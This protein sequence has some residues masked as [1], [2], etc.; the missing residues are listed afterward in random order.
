MER[1]VATYRITAPASESRARA[2]A[3]ATEQSVEM[4]L[5]AIEDPR[6]LE[7]IVAQVLD[8]RPRGAFFEVDLGIAPETTGNEPAQLMNMLFGNCS[9]Q[10]EIELVDVRFPSGYERSFPGPRFGIDGI[11]KITGAEGRPLTCTALK[12]QGSSI[13]HLAGVAHTFALAGIDVIKD[14]HG[15]ANQHS[16]PF[17]KRVPAV[18]KAINEA[19]RETGGHTVYAPTFSGG[20][21]ALAGQAH[22]AKDSGVRMALIA[23]MLVGIPAF[24]EAQAELDIPLMAHPAFAGAGRIAPAALLGKL[25]R[26]FGADATIFPNHGGRF[27]YD[28]ETC[29]LIAEAARAPWAKVKPALPVPAGGMTVERVDEMVRDYGCDVMLLIG[30]GLLSAKGKLLERSRE[31]VSKVAAAGQTRA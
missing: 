10:P 30:G 24:V 29:I 17:D 12:P 8:I 28:R 20:S 23:P 15:L 19:N 27:S 4:P 7:Q 18:Q 5:E 16:A 6:V 1:I 11:R 14:D 13:E 3:L 21:I 22:V 31:F 9:L 2:D 25:F 26:L